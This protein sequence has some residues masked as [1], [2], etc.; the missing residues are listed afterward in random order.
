MKPIIVTAFILCLLT[1]AS[2]CNA[3]TAYTNA[4]S[5]NT[6]IANYNFKWTYNFDSLASGASAAS[7]GMIGVCAQG[8]ASDGSTSNSLELVTTNAYSPLSSPNMAGASGSENQFLAGNSDQIKFTFTHPVHAFGMYLIGNPSPTGS[9]AI[10]FWKM[11]AY[12]SSGFDAYSATDPLITISLG[13]DLYFLGIVSPHDP[14]T[15]V[16]LYSDNDIAAVYSFNF[17]DI[18]VAADAQNAS[19]SE[20]KGVQS[21]DVVVSNVV[22]T[23]VHANRFN[24]EDR[25]RIAGMAILG[26]GTTRGKAISLF[27]TI[28]NTADDERVLR[29][30]QI[31]NE[32]DST[33]PDPLGMI[34]KAAGGMSDCGYQVGCAGSIGLNNI[35]LDI[36]IWGKVTGFDDSR[37]HSW[38]T[39]D[40]GSGRD[41][42]MGTLGVKVEG[43]GVWGSG[44]YIGE[45]VRIQGSSSLFKQ[46][47]NHYPVI[48]IAEPGDIKHIY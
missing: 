36:V 10:P 3:A 22:V 46:D 31:L 14:F 4:T 9:P 20:I 39:I 43:P 1:S 16:D 26:S 7:C 33:A 8:L 34:G 24:I 30:V 21:G 15:E 35:G 44:R 32:T 27:G 45:T 41:S 28:E 13:N 25:D 37:S 11:H 6:A 38:I 5:F 17:D 12:N 23:R 18:T 48:R 47:S 40:D 19:L 2:T 42:K 29:L